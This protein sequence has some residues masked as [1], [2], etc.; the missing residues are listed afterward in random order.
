ML[1]NTKAIKFLASGHWR[2]WVKSLAVGQGLRW[3]HKGIKKKVVALLSPKF[4]SNQMGL[5]WASLKCCHWSVTG[6][7]GHEFQK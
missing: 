4:A 7:N 1:A 2:R 5:G 3:H 6:R